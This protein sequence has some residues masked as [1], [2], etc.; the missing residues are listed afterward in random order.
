MLV[1]IGSRREGGNVVDLFLDCHA[2][3]R[4]FAALAV[5]LP[6]GPDPTEIATTA[7]AIRRYFAEALPL[8][9]ADEELEVHPRLA[10]RDPAVDAA[11]AT[12]SAEHAEHEPAVARLIA[13]C[14]TLAAEPARLAALAPELTTLATDLV[15][16]FETHLVLEES[17]IFPALRA[18]PAADLETLRLA[19]HA[20][21]R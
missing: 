21:R 6:A 15:A 5:R 1:S 8:H 12:M 13:V 18:L 11:L 3:I 9:V 2:R 17:V 7:A 20:R 19:V 10:G 14:T 4:R 16:R